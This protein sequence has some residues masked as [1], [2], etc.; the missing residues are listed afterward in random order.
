MSKVSKF[1]ISL[2]F[3]IC[4]L[5]VLCCGYAFADGTDDADYEEVPVFVDGLLSCR[6]YSVGEET[7]VSLDAVCGVLGYESASYYD[8]ETNTLT[9]TVDDILITVCADDK[10]MTANGRC[11]YLPDG[12]KEIEG[13]P[14]FPLEAIAKIFSLELREDEHGTFDFGTANEKILESGDEYYDADELYWMSRVIT[15]ESG[16]QLLEGQ[17]GVGNVVMN[18]IDD[19]RF[20]NSIKDVI[21]EQGQFLV[22]DSGAIYGDPRELSVVAAK[23]TLE[24]YNTVDD[25]VFF[26]TGTVCDNAELVVTIDDHSFFR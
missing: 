10:Y 19:A 2:V 18:R 24:G 14:V 13:T 26:Q 6:G 12:Y 5:C 23:L 25:A 3:V 21:F 15:W 1:N 8:I 11:L 20:A 9:V 16:N 22:V 17:I 4:L 7:Y